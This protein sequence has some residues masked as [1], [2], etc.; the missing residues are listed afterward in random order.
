MGPWRHEAF[1]TA[2][3]SV[4]HVHIDC[5]AAGDGDV[6]IDSSLDDVV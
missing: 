1:D 2:C 4:D 3:D 6:A 5:A